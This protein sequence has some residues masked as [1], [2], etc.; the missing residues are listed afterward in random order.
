MLP[1]GPGGPAVV[2]LA[3]RGASD[4]TVVHG[5][6]LHQE[7]SDG[8][9]LVLVPPG[10]RPCRLAVERDDHAA[11]V[12]SPPVEVSGPFTFARATLPPFGAVASPGFL[13]AAAGPHALVVPL[14]HAPRAPGDPHPAWLEAHP[15]TAVNGV[16]VAGLDR[17]QL[18]DLV[19]GPAGRRVLL[20]LPC[21][22]AFLS[23][24]CPAAAFDVTFTRTAPVPWGGGRPPL[25]LVRAWVAD[26][27]LPP[28]AVQAAL[29]TSARAAGTSPP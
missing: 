14:H 22:G 28:E 11:L 9:A 18:L 13:L 25:D 19:E 20:T 5:C 2:L 26:H 17:W 24:P 10:P 15:V 12:H 16:P 7:V 6:G 21:E 23:R 29:L 1:A 3:V 27:D 8:L 4:L